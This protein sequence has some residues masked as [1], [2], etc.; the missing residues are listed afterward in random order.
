M[1]ARRMIPW[2]V[3]ALAGAI[4]AAA[5]P[6]H[7]DTVTLNFQSIF[8]GSAPAGSGPWLTA[9]FT[10]VSAGTVLLTVNASGLT[11]NESVGELYFNLNPASSASML[12]FSRDPASTGPSAANTTISLGT[13]AFRADGDGY[14]DVLLDLPPPPGSQAARFTAGESLVYTI[15]GIPTLSAACFLFLSQPGPGAGPGPQFA[16]AHIEQI[17][18]AGASG[19]AGAVL[20]A[21][22]PLPGAAWLLISGLAL[23]GRRLR[24]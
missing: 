15:T 9:T 11:A 6:A 19:W 21:P 12:V 5:L 23:L 17:G 3:A 16:A 14:Y 24:P 22:V 10:D 2:K 4:A 13:N 7:A 20:A 18:A 1:R 8:S